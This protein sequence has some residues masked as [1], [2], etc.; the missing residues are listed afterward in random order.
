MLLVMALPAI[1]KHG[2]GLCFGKSV[3]DNVLVPRFGFELFEIVVVDD[4]LFKRVHLPVS[5]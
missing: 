3:S 4:P 5:N 1:E 2:I